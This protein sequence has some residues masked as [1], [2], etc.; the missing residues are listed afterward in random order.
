MDISLK[1]VLDGKRSLGGFAK[2]LL[3]SLRS[4]LTDLKDV[5]RAA[6]NASENKVPEM[7]GRSR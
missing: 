1:K 4:S 5:K 3:C 6:K 2:T 7:E